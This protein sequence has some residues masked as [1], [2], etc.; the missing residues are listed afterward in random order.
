MSI[1]LVSSSPLI[2]MIIA[3]SMRRHFALFALAALAAL[4]AQAKDEGDARR[5]TT[6]LEVRGNVATPLTLSVPDLRKFVAHRVDDARVVRSPAAW[7]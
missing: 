4:P 5:V 7:R 6:T 2:D 3:A 1:D